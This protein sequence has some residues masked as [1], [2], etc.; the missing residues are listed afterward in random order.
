MICFIHLIC[1]LFYFYTIFYVEVSYHAMPNT[2]GSFHHRKVNQWQNLHCSSKGKLKGSKDTVDI[3]E[4]APREIVS[5]VLKPGLIKRCNNDVQKLNEVKFK[6]QNFDQVM[7]EFICC[8]CIPY[9]G[10]HRCRN[11]RNQLKKV[12]QNDNNKG[13]GK[14]IQTSCIQLQRAAWQKTRVTQVL[15]V[16]K[17]SFKWVDKRSVFPSINSFRRTWNSKK[18]ILCCIKFQF[19]GL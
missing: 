8:W 17:E 15:H 19:T 7:I 12:K 16:K 10:I 9:Y 14:T 4:M 5:N 18:K 11:T 6:C 13:E 3:S 1:F 2:H